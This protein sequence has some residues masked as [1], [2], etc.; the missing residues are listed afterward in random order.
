MDIRQREASL[1][2]GPHHETECLSHLQ[3]P[4]LQ[5]LLLQGLP[6]AIAEAVRV[7]Y[8]RSDCFLDWKGDVFTFE[9]NIVHI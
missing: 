5:S 9:Q 8:E 1:C 7:M 2:L 4:H 3:S 6:R